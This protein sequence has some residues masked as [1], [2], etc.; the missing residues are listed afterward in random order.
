MKELERKSQPAGRQ[1]NVDSLEG[2]LA[3]DEGMREVDR[4]H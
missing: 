3:E 4:C 2:W 1:D